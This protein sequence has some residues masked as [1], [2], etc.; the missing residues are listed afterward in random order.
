MKRWRCVDCGAV[1]TVR[2]A[3]HWRGLWAT[4]GLILE[5]LGG[6]LEG[7]RWLAEV[8]R[9]RQQ[10][11]WQGFQRQRRLAGAPA[12]LSDLVVQGVILATHS[13]R[14]RRQEPLSYDP[15]RI[16]AVT[17]ATTMS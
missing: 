2:P 16:F 3:S 1:H 14:Y 7:R 13:M 17:A 6:K 5:S 9:Q 10:Y 11:W 12:P 4:I 15:H 8:S